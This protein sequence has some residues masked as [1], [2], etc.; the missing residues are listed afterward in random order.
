MKRAAGSCDLEARIRTLIRH[1]IAA[2]FPAGRAIVESIFDETYVQLALAGAA[3]LLAIALIFGH[4][5]LH[6]AILSLSDSCH[7]PTV[8]PVRGS[9]KFRW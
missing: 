6:A 9:G 2:G 4:V 1:L 5:A 8:A 3:V 7:G